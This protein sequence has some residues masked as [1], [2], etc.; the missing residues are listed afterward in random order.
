MDSPGT[1][2]TRLV[3]VILFVTTSNGVYRYRQ[4][5]TRA[6]RIL[7]NKHTPGLFNRKGKGYFGISFHRSSGRLLVASR[8]RLGT[9]RVDKPTTDCKLIWLDPV[10]GEQELAAEIRDV[11][12]VHQIACRDS[13]V[14]LTDT[15]K[16]RILDYDLAAGSLAHIVNIGTE[17]C[18]INHLNALHTN[19]QRLQIGLNNRGHQ[20]S[21]IMTVTV[22]E[23]I[24]APEIEITLGLDGRTNRMPEMYHTHDI[25]PYDGDF[26]VC[27]S[28]AGQVFMADQREAIIQH[29]GWVRGLSVANEGIWV[30]ISPKAKRRNRHSDKLSGAICLYA[31]GDLACVHTIALTGSGQVNDICCI[32]E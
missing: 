16:N 31:H 32:D 26:L 29:N 19:G 22:E 13:H 11:H 21:A 15:G 4:D 3:V 27:S 9:A 5:A 12:D 18:D 17:R 20:E 8:E 30:G 24:D 28:G 25:E 14:F 2:V 23:I 6:E 7:G 10:T 1:S